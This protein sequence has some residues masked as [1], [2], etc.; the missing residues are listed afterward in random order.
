MGQTFWLTVICILL[1]VLAFNVAT[2]WLGFRK[3]EEREP[4]DL[5]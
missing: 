1:A 5:W 2:G 4:H 3:D